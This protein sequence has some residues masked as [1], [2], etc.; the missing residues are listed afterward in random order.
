M[1]LRS[2]TTVAPLRVG[3]G[4][5]LEVLL[6]PLGRED[7]ERVR[8]AYAMLSTE[9]RMNRFWEKPAELSESRAESLTDVD[10]QNHVAWAA[11][12][13][14]EGDLPGYAGASFWRSEEEPEKAELAFT[15]ADAFQRRGL[16]TMLFSI[17]WIEAWEVGVREF[18]GFCRPRNEGMISWWEGIGGTVIRGPYQAEL[19]WVIERPE[20]FLNRVP[21]EMPP[22]LRRVEIAEWMERWLEKLEE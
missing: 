11:L 16:A 18:I 9:S 21:F 6:R 13:I 12:P 1:K 14:E 8:R 19:R 15:V 3:L 22:S 10:D 20:D 5:D 4:D 7:K 2:L 17:L